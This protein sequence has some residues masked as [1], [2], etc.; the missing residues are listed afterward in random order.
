TS[1]RMILV[2][3]LA[4]FLSCAPFRYMMFLNC[5]WPAIDFY[6]ASLRH[7]AGRLWGV[8]L[9][10]QY[11]R[12]GASRDPVGHRLPAPLWRPGAGSA[13]GQM[14]GKATADSHRLD[15]PCQAGAIVG[16]EQ[17]AAQRPFPLRRLRAL[18]R[19]LGHKPPYRRLLLHADDRII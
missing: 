3:T 10:I 12:I 4:R 13:S 1:S 14:P 18:A 16:R 11:G 9:T 5:E 8:G 6:A 15:R 17:D 2:K 7:S 19:H